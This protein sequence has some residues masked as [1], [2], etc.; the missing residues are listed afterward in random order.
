MIFFTKERRTARGDIC[1]FRRFH[2]EDDMQ[3]TVNQERAMGCNHSFTGKQIQPDSKTP[4][5]RMDFGL[6]DTQQTAS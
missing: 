2:R 4:V 5:S 3:I 6:I 1:G